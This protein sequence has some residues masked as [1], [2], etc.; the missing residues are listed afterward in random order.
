MCELDNFEA[1]FG[2]NFLDAYHVDVL[3]SNFKLKIKT[4][5][6]KKLINLKVEY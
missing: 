2:N 5:L 4:R 1:I 6:S 3:R